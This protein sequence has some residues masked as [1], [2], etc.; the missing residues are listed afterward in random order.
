MIRYSDAWSHFF[1]K[2]NDLAVTF[3]NKTTI[4]FCE[5]YGNKKYVH[6]TKRFKDVA[7]LCF[8]FIRFVSF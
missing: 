8:S 2:R 3:M 5:E 7:V 6:G 1:V 4:I